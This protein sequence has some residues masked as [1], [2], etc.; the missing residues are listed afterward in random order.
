MY[1][2]PRA[3]FIN[4]SFTIQIWWKC[5]L[6]FFLEGVLLFISW[7]SD[8]K[9][10]QKCTYQDSY[11][12]LSSAKFCSNHFI[13]IWMWTKWYF[14][15]SWIVME[16]S[17]VKQDPD[18]EFIGYL[19]VHCD[20]LAPLSHQFLPRCAHSIPSW[21]SLHHAPYHM[22]RCGLLMPRC[23]STCLLT[24]LGSRSWCWRT[25]TIKY[26]NTTNMLMQKYYVSFIHDT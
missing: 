19:G 1:R 4:F 23:L 8:C 20:G 21:S 2:E 14:H 3:H 6:V 12:V 18:T 26:S 17:L 9:Q 22:L 25:G 7:S 15:R 13:R 10:Q 16:K 24:W 11:A 5:F